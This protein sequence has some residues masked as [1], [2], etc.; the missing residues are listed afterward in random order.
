MI[1]PDTELRLV[2]ARIGYGVFASAP[3]PKGSILYVQDPLEIRVSPELYLTLDETCR[4]SVDKYS[5]SAP[6]VFA[7]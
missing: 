6:T 1:H 7:Y 2:D 5:S 3:I 4:Q